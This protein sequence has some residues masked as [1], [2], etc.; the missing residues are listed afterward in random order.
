MGEQSYNTG[1]RMRPPFRVC[2]RL[3]HVL[4]V[5]FLP[6]SKQ[7]DVAGSRNRKEAAGLTDPAG[8]RHNNGS[9]E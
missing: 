5:P 3:S 4:T 1:S 9:P 6:V 2:E 7:A 8:Q